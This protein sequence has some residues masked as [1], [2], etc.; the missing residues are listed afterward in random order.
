M[1]WAGR[2]SVAILLVVACVA[3]PLV[4]DQCATSCEAHSSS[5]AAAPSCHHTGSLTERVGSMPAPCGH[6][7]N[8]P[9]ATAAVA[10]SPASRPLVLM[11][12][13]TIDPMAANDLVAHWID[14]PSAT[15]A[16]IS[17]SHTLARP[18]RI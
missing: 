3:L 8:G 13:I 18:L 16:P 6:D 7:H 15:P 1:S 14:A 11:P 4:L 9:V 17:H 12:A 10:P 5:S 2:A